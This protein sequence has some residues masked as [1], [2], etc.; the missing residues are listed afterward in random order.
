MRAGT[1]AMTEAQ[2]SLLMRVCDPRDGRSRSEFYG[3]YR[4]VLII[5][6]ASRARGDRIRQ[7]TLLSIAGH[8]LLVLSF[9]CFH[10]PGQDHPWGHFHHLDGLAAIGLM[11]TDRANRTR[12]LARTRGGRG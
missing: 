7:T 6:W 9:L 12:A 2:V 1:I 4:A 10:S 8:V 5:A 11:P 3:I